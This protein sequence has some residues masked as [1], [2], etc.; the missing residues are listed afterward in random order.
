LSSAP[1][2]VLTVDDEPLALQRISR[3]VREEPS[4]S[5]VAECSSAQSAID[6]ICE[7][8]P[9]VV[10]LDVQMPEVDGFGVLDALD[11]SMLPWIVFTTA[12]EEYAVRA[13]EASAVDYLLKPISKERFA[14]AVGKVKA[15]ANLG[16]NSNA[17]AVLDVTRYQRLL[18][19]TD[20][21][22]VMLDPAHVERISAAGNYAIVYAGGKSYVIRETMTR[23]QCRLDPHRFF[24]VNR[25]EIVNLSFV[26]ELEPT[27]H[28]EYSV[29]TI[30]GT[31]VN[32]TRTYRD[33]LQRMLSM[34][35]AE[36]KV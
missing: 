29:T 14:A 19:K 24:R 28:G 35:R 12:Y 2:R 20:G 30:Y 32:L 17:R 16:G 9:Q 6:G 25:S 33:A 21:K 3:L 34:A 10:F 5:L 18:I 26:Q 4:F 36:N 22:Y 13:F 7:L 8:R 27:A 31:K 1:I 23:I 11:G 15:A